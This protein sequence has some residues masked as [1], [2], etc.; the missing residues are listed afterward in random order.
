MAQVKKEKKRKKLARDLNKTQDRER[1][2]CFFQVLHCKHDINLGYLDVKPEE[3]E[4]VGRNTFSYRELD[5]LF[6]EKKQNKN[7]KNQANRKGD[8]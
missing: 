8:S 4:G 3:R 2:W 6:Q 7:K 1:G 5:S